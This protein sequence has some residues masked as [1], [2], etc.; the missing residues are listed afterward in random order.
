MKIILIFARKYITRGLI[1]LLGVKEKQNGN[2]TICL[3]ACGHTDVVY[4]SGK[5]CY[6]RS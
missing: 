1:K 4:I 2:I 3:M 5:E 6:G